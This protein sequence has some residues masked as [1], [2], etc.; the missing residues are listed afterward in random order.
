MRV[1]LEAM[2]QQA[3]EREE[4]E[5]RRQREAAPDGGGASETEGIPAAL[6]PLTDLTRDEGLCLYA[7]GRWTEAGEALGRYLA[8]S[9]DAPDSPWIRTVLEKVWA[10]QRRAAGNG[11]GGGAGEGGAGGSAG[12]VA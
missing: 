5:R 8:T 1:T 6:G 10:A 4:Q 3:E 11:N 7:L 2:F 9:P 12:G